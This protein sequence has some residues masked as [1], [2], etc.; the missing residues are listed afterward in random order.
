[1]P[2]MAAIVHHGGIGTAALALRAGRPSAIAP[3]MTDQ[4]FWAD[5][6]AGK[7]VAPKPVPRG[8]LTLPALTAAL[9]QALND[10]SMQ[11]RAAALGALIGE[12][13]GVNVAAARIEAIAARR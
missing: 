7:S 5:I 3:F 10:R 13:D 11:Q 9:E 6:L 12:E 1:M 8:R 4:L 2:H